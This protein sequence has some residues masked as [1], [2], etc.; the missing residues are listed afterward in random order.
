MSRRDRSGGPRSIT[1]GLGLALA[2]GMVAAAR[3]NR[4]APEDRG[5]LIVQPGG[6]P[7]A[8]VTLW[9]GL[10]D[11]PPATP[12]GRV[13]PPKT[14][15]RGVTDAT[16][17]LVFEADPG[18]CILHGDGVDVLGSAERGTFGRKGI[19]VVPSFRCESALIV[20][21]RETDWLSSWY[22]PA[23]GFSPVRR[24]PVASLASSAREL[25]LEHGQRRDPLE[26]ERDCAI[27]VNDSRPSDAL[28][29]LASLT[30][31]ILA[32][33]P[34]PSGGFAPRETELPALDARVWSPEALC[35]WVATPLPAEIVQAN[36]YRFK[37][38]P[39]PER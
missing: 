36:P 4:P 13:R 29:A 39:R 35:A 18:E 30:R 26:R 17:R 21:E 5:A 38:P 24:T 23:K 10:I 16:G 14:W 28:S 27:V 8:G 31:P 37:C 33:H 25:W 7:A 19:V 32:G 15:V 1:L 12:D 22:H 3:A 34:D 9:C 2:L 11:D 20:V 6:L